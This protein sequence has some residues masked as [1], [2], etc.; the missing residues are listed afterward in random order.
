LHV[1]IEDNGRGLGAAPEAVGDGLS[2]MRARLEALGGGAEIEPRPGGGTVVRFVL[3]M[4]AAARPQD[5]SPA[6]G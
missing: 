2:N 6:P 3:P 1:S 5:H 4:D